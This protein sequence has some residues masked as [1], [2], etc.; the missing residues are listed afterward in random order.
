MNWA[1]PENVSHFIKMLIKD[2]PV[3]VTEAGGGC[4]GKVKGGGQGGA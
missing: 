4:K 1:T 2:C 3:I